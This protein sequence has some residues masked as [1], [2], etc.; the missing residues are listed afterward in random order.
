MLISFSHRPRAYRLGGYRYSYD[1]SRSVM[2]DYN[3]VIKNASVMKS[4][5]GDLPASIKAESCAG[6]N[7]QAVSLQCVSS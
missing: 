1:A 4:Y 3:L 7:L 5:M 2:E 6:D